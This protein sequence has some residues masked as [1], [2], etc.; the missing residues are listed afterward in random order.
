MI[1][2]FQGRKLRP[3]EA[4]CLAQGHTALLPEAL[5]GLFARLPEAEA[6]TASPVAHSATGSPLVTPSQPRGHKLS[7]G[8]GHWHLGPGALPCLPPNLLPPPSGLVAH[9]EPGAHG[10]VPCLGR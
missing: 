4:E 5:W 1:P 10:V 6:S 9:A 8:T 7:L 3:G 2:I